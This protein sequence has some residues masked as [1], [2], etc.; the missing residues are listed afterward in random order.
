[1]S[2]N[3]EVNWLTMCDKVGVKCLPPWPLWWFEISQTDVI[4]SILFFCFSKQSTI[5]E[6]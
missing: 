1:M 4:V 2:I 3:S 6:T 5:I